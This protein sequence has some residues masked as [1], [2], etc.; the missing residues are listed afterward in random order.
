MSQ[1]LLGLTLLA[2]IACTGVAHAQ[3]T[4]APMPVPVPSASA[5][6]P[7]AAAKQT[8]AATEQ[9][10]AS[11]SAGEL[12]AIGVGVVAG[13]VLFDGVVLDGFSIVG[14]VLGGWAGDY[15]Y[16]THVASKGAS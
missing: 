14:A 4:A 5:P 3:G 11:L 2:S 16:K 12:A 7:G 6:S 10:G 1:R 13:V 8:L 9:W 15:I